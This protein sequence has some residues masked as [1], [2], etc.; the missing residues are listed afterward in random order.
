MASLKGDDTLTDVIQNASSV[1][2]NVLA[3][4]NCN[5]MTQFMHSIFLHFALFAY[6][7]RMELIRMRKALPQTSLGDAVVVLL[8]KMTATLQ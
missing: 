7:T 1:Y 3:R 8:T 5:G 2:D 4:S 6:R